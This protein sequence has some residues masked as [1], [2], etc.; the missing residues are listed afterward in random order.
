MKAFGQFRRLSILVATFLL[1]ILVSVQWPSGAAQPIRP[2]DPV[3]NTI[4]ELELE[5]DE[6]KRT[7]VELRARLNQQQQATLGQTTMLVQVRQELALQKMR[8]GL[9]DLRGP[10]VRVILN[11]APRS[12]GANPDNLLV[13][14]YDIRDVV[15]VLWLAGAEAISVNEERLV[16]TT[17]IYCVGSTIMINE[18]RLSPPYQIRAIGDPL[19]LQDFLNN[20]GYLPQ[21]RQRVERYGIDLQIVPVD[22]M[23]VPAYRGSFT[24]RYARPGS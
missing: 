20:P 8:A 18:T 13:H 7:I 11:D 1:G 14:D 24:L 21:L 16:N 17:S 3:S 5:Q 23:T 9:T 4:H 12:A 22:M 19:R 10:G 2:A 6:L 15:S